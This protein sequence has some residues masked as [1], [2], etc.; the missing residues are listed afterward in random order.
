MS[1]LHSVKITQLFSNY[2]TYGPNKRK[3]Q[4]KHSNS[5]Y[6]PHVEKA[7]DSM[8]HDGLL[9]KM[10]SMNIPLQLIKITESFLSERTFSV[11][12]ENR[13]SSIKKANAGVPQEALVF[14]LRSLILIRMTYLHFLNLVS[15]YLRMTQCFIAQTTMRVLHLSNSKNK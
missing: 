7:F 4:P 12:I 3:S 8:W 6:L 11:K 1:N 13:N 14:P 15:P 9:H 10:M 2:Q 5:C